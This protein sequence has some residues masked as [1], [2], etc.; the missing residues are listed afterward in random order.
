LEAAKCIAL[1]ATLT[2][3]ASP[4]LKAALESSEAVAD[5]IG[6]T[7]EELRIAMFGIGAPDLA[8]LRLTPLLRRI[9]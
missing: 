3:M 7:A 9:E 2:S 8:H 1:G 6:R 4:Y 5:V